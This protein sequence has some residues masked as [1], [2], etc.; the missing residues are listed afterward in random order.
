MKRILVGLAL[1]SSAALIT[2]APAQAA[3]VDPSKALKKQYVAG[4]GVRFSETTRSQADGK[5]VASLSRTGALEFGKKGVIAGE[6][7]TKGKGSELTP[8][9]MIVVG[10]STYA[11][12]DVFSEDLPEG[13]KWVRYPG[14]AN[15][16]VSGQPLDIF[17]PKVLKR[18]VT[19]AKSFKGGAYRGS[20]TFAEMSKLY[21]ERIDKKLG[22]IKIAYVLGANSKGLITGV[23]SEFTMDFGLLGKST[24]IVSTRYTGWGAKI[25]IKAPP[26]DEVIDSDELGSD[27]SVPQEIPNGSLNSFAGV[28]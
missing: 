12:G 6:V 9:R 14:G 1:A 13:K 2:A 17:E 23:R 4:H 20:V 16:R 15:A 18:L 8:P 27:T 19:K 25:T 22:K 24:S 7:R 26:A 10:D 21:G 28:Q 3:P 5:T 11:Q